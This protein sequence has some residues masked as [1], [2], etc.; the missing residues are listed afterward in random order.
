MAN[1]QL[2]CIA[3]PCIQLGIL[4]VGCTAGKAFGLIPSGEAVFWHFTDLPE[5]LDAQSPIKHK[6]QQTSSHSLLHGHKLVSCL[7]TTTQAG[8]CFILRNVV[9]QRLRLHAPASHVRPHV[10]S[11]L[12]PAVAVHFSQP[13][14]LCCTTTNAASVQSLCCPC[15]SL[16]HCAIYGH[17]CHCKL[18]GFKESLAFSTMKCDH[19]LI[20]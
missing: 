17:L 11:G 16:P 14:C 18:G 15:S 12:Q 13:T 7:C 3:K 20:V 5:T 10:L 19:V 6:V 9:K 1:L 4:C 8:G 2:Q